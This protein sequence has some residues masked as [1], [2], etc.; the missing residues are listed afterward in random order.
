MTE[1]PAA[2]WTLPR[3]PLCV[4]RAAPIALATAGQATARADGRPTLLHV[5]GPPAIG[6]TTL[7]VHLAYLLLRDYPDGGLFLD[8][9][10]SAARMVVPPEDLARQ[11]L[12]QFG[13]PAAEIPAAPEDLLAVARRLLARK[14]MVL[15]IDDVSLSG[16]VEELLG[17]VSNALVIVTSRSRHDELAAAGFTRI[18]LTG[19]DVAAVGELITAMGGAGAVPDEV[20]RMLCAKCTGLP[21]ALKVGAG[22]IISGEEDPH[23]LVATL[24]L[25]DLEQDEE[26]SVERV[27]DAI[28]RDLPDDEQTDYRAW[29]AMPVADFGLA[30]SA[31]VLGCTQREA[32]RRLAKLVRRFLI[33]DCGAGRYR[34]HYLLREHAAKCAAE[35]SPEQAQEVAERATTWLA[36]RAIALDRAYAPRP[37]PQGSEA[38]YASIESAYDDADKA[39]QEYTVEWLNLLTAAHS[40]TE[41]GWF[42]LA[43]AVPAALYSFAYQ[44]RRTAALIDLYVRALDFAR[45]APVQWQLNRDLAGLHEQLGEGEAA[46][47]FAAA[48]LGTGYAPGTSSAHEWMGLGYEGLGR[49]TEA[50]DS[51]TLALST[52]DLMDDPVQE[53]R[54]AA[55]LRMHLARVA[56]KLE[57]FDDAELALSQ[58]KE[59]FAQQDR[60]APNLARCE[61][62]LGDLELKAGDEPAAEAR[63]LTAG[64]IYE[65]RAMPKNAADVLDKLGDLAGSQQRPGEARAYRDRAKELRGQAE[66]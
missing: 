9:H 63:W 51:L 11:V 62:L 20:I 39:S 31:E 42:D 54:A 49:L 46:V 66:G 55:L 8:A 15:V 7:A 18:V 59:Y 24:G 44:T 4:D 65:R 50:R 17:D 37:V 38:L 60:D 33:E 30:I 47:R 12:V 35:K 56:W 25:A 23:E 27:F 29:G 61:E 64:T 5:T 58:A 45:T 41:F 40:C 48:A 34:F 26:V 3:D 52:V 57:S 16:Q 36:R 21:L 22:R 10:G 28:Y 6:K 14:R 32:R 53:Q 1:Q 13:T 2:P 43:V 19:F